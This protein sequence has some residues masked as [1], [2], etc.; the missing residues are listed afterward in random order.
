MRIQLGLVKDE[1]G[2]FRCGSVTE[3]K[4]NIL[5]TEPWEIEKIWRKWSSYFL[6]GSK[7]IMLLWRIQWINYLINGLFPLK[8]GESAIYLEYLFTN[9]T[10][11]FECFYGDPGFI[12][13]K[14]YIIGGPSLRKRI[15]KIKIKIR[16]MVLGGP[17]AIWDSLKLGFVA[18]MVGASQ[19]AQL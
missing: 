7:E 8:S 16:Y 14:A 9:F 17:C 13:P 18:F 12:D 1:K 19:V 15:Q 10:K 4:K 5:N 2:P 6:L 11:F 3:V